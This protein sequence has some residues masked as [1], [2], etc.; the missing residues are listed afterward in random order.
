MKSKKFNNTLFDDLD[1]L[2]DRILFNGTH[3][4]LSNMQKRIIESYFTDETTILFQSSRQTGRTFAIAIL[5]YL[6][7]NNNPQIT[8]NTPKIE[9][10]KYIL[11]VI[12]A[13]SI[14][15]NDDEEKELMNKKLENIRTVSQFLTPCRIFD[16]VGTIMKRLCSETSN[17]FIESQSMHEYEKNNTKTICSLSDDEFDSMNTL[18]KNIICSLPTTDNLKDYRAIQVKRFLV[19]GRDAIC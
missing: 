2:L 6:V 12:D 5:L 13:I 3:R 18:L 15:C 19:E 10:Q 7:G 8:Y 4:Q 9:M 16:D 11:K 1:W 17:P 14:S